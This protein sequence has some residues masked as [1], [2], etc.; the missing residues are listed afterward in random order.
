MRVCAV[1]PAHNEEGRVGQIVREAGKYVHRVIV[2][3]DGSRDDT[4]N[5]AA[6]AGAKVIRHA[7]NLGVGA[8]TITGNEYATKKGFD[9]IVN[10]DSDGQHSAKSIPEGIELLR[11]RKL[12]F[13]FGSRFLNESKSFPLI[14]KF[15]NLFLT[16]MNK[17]MF[18][19]Y[20]SDTQSG[21]RIFTRKAWLK[22][23]LKSS[24]YP[25]CSEIAKEVGRK[26]LK[27]MEI[28]VDT[29]YL[30]RFKGTTVF[31]GIEV[32]LNMIRWWLKK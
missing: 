7:T 18:G 13:V 26:R 10:L 31:D 29:I 19:T 24:G 21:F 6:A 1:L 11:E 30:D 17:L 27:Y 23:D 25:I 22:L 32:F 12:D 20:I 15:G 4:A 14:L 3:D 16:R 5:E 8:A 28:P 9:V 2:V